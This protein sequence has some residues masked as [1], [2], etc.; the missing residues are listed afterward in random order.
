MA[1]DELTLKFIHR[2]KRPE[3]VNTILKDKNKVGGLTGLNHKTYYKAVETRQCSTDEP[4]DKQIDRTEGPQIDPHIISQLIFGKGVKSIELSKDNL[5]NKWC[6]NNWTFITKSQSRYRPY[7]LHKNQ[8]RMGHR[9][10]I[11]G[12]CLGIE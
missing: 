10:G 11:E 6:W 8:L 4:Q 1:I 2:D 3:T 5:F 7:T 12:S 9:P